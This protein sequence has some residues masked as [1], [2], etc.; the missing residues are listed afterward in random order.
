MTDRQFQP[1]GSTGARGSGSWYVTFQARDG[2]KTVRYQ[3]SVTQQQ[4]MLCS[5]GRRV[6]LVVSDDRLRDLR[7][8]KD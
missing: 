8:A 4:Y 5:E 1:V 3:F 7:P 2:D 6:E